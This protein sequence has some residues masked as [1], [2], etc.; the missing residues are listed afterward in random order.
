MIKKI[1][2]GIPDLYVLEPKVFRDSRG[3]FVETYNERTMKGA[4]LHYNFVQDN[5][6]ESTYGTLR[7][8][9]FQKGEFA[10]AKLV[11][12]IRGEVLDI[13]VD[14][15]K[16]SPTYGKHFGV[17]LSEA[18]KKM[19]IVPR[20]FAHGFV[21]LSDVAVFSYK[22]DNFYAPGNEGGIYFADPTL[23]I[24]WQVPQE[25]IILSDK[26]RKN[27]LFQPE[28]AQTDFQPMNISLLNLK[29]I[30]DERGKLI[31]LESGKNVPFDIKRVYYIYNTLEGVRR[32]FHS[33]R[34]L[35]QIC[36]AVQGSC[37]F[38]LDDG[39]TKQS[40]ILDNP[41][42]GL[43]INGNIWREMHDFSKDCVLMVL[44]DQH[45]NES[46]YIRNYDTFLSYVKN[47]S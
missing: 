34:S 39:K 33:H 21:V 25:K 10:Q 19:M 26:D 27:P 1:E 36:V 18:N 5:E 7:G 30:G 3:Y 20:G 2:T 9:H 44:A 46:D 35:R 28:C 8:L 47:E 45:Y 42:K 11:R 16:D 41:N 14:L 6:S 40:V 12:A 24:D 38:A 31:S 29:E 43:L 15:R 17:I 32:G 23:N 22:C 13:A 4:G 37:K